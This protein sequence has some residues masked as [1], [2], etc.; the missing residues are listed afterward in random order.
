MQTFS[1]FH[2]YSFVICLC[3]KK[4]STY[5][6]K[7]LDRS[8]PFLSQQTKSGQGSKSMAKHEYFSQDFCCVDSTF[9]EVFLNKKLC[10]TEE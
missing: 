2:Y 6:I 8:F 10:L 7:T 9:V 1:Y 3:D 4:I 5:D